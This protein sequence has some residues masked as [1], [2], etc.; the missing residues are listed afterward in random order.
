MPYY[1]E[2]IKNY[3][4]NKLQ[5]IKNNIYTKVAPLSS[6]AWTSK[7]PLS[8]K[9]RF[10]GKKK[11]IKI[12]DQWGKLWS[13]AWF[14]FTGTVPQKAKGSK[15]VLLIDLSGEGC[16][17]DDEGVPIRG[18]TTVSST[19]DKS[20]GEPGKRVVQFLDKAQGKEEVDIWIDAGNNDLFGNFKNDGVLKEASIAECDPLYRKLYYDFRI[21]F[22]LME[23]LDEDSARYHTLLHNL[24][25]A[26]QTIKNYTAPE[27]KKARSI[28]KKELE[29]ENGDYSLEVSAIGHAHLD[30]AWLWPIR[31]TIR[32]AARTFSTVLELMDRYPDYIFGASQPQLYQWVKEYYPELYKKIKEKVKEGRWEVQ[33]GMWVESDMNIPDGESLIRQILYGKKFFKEEFNQDIETLWLP[34]V[35]GYSAALPQILKKSGIDYFMTQKLSWNNY[36]DFPHHSFWWEGLDGS[37]VLTHMLP[38]ETYNSSGAPR[39]V[40]KAEKNYK[41]KGISQNCMMLYGIGDGGG[42]PGAEHLEAVKREKNLNGIAPV[43]QEFSRDFFKK[44]EKN[45]DQYKKWSGELYLEKHQGTYTIQ[46]KNKK[47]NRKLEIALKKLEHNSVLADIYSDYNYPQAE[48][49]AI[50][51]KV[52]LYQFHDI[53]PGSSIDRVHNESVSDYENLAQKIEALNEKASKKILNNTK[54]AD[55]LTYNYL[56]WDRKEWLNVDDSWLYLEISALSQQNLKEEEFSQIDQGALK[57]AANRIE[58]DL[59]KVEFDQDGSITSV[60][61]KKQDKEVLAADQKANLLNVYDDHG[62]AWDF[63]AV[64][65]K[66]QKDSFKLESSDSFI[67][68]P[69]VIMKQNYSYGDSKLKQK[70][71]IQLHSKRIDFQTNVDWQ[72]RKKMLRVSFPLNIYANKVNCD[73]QLGSL[74][75]PT[76]RNTSWDSAKYEIPAQKWVDMSQGDYGAALINDCKYGYKAKDNVLDLNLLRSPSY[77]GKNADLGKHEFKYALFPHS[78][79]HIEAEVDKEA[80]KLNSP[81]EI[82]KV[83]KET[84]EAGNLDL[85]NSLIKSSSNNIVISAVKKAEKDE[86]IIIRLHENFGRSEEINLKFNFTNKKIK[87]LNETNLMETKLKKLKLDNNKTKLSFK[88]YEIKT[89]KIFLED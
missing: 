86:A 72:E 45:Q 38:E 58:N 75:R 88:P 74:E 79:D 5:K 23:V 22:S 49:E 64:Y 57:A 42:G 46:A 81:L 37:K 8:F 53:L 63:T 16:V 66:Y 70:I 59:L 62:N 13:C 26:A 12:D 6:T 21:L 19:F 36:N 11:S 32:K 2:E 14:N 20:L 27:A 7:D 52:L 76:H 3:I 43:K 31:E 44:L 24:E 51:K 56:S 25:K 33:G 54:T 48:I 35:F 84:E 71:V 41:D 89:L 17:V 60:Y 34:D 55:Y 29:K 83:A 28:L 9:E 87:K 40:A 30:L 18:L 47:Y 10:K 15:V 39:A 50:W 69:Q 68:G 65:D 73:I 77:P 80:N 4:K 85:S 1:K 82:K 61:D 78:G 67:S